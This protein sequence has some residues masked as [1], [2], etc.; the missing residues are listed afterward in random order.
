MARLIETDWP[1]FG[2]PALPPAS[3]AALYRGRIALLRARMEAAGLSVLLVYGDREHM[4]NL[5]WLTG[6]DPRFEEAVAVVRP[7]GP[8]RLLVGNEGW[9]YVPVSPL[10][11][12]DMAREVWP[13]FSLMNQPRAGARPLRHV[14]GEAMGEAGPGGV[15]CGVAGWKAFAAED[16]PE[17]GQMI[18]APAFVVDAARAAAARVVDAAALFM[19]PG[20]GLRATASA[21]E[22]AAHD[23]ANAIVT[24]AMRRVL[25]GLRPGM[26]DLEAAGLGRLGGM[27]LSCHPT[28]CTGAA[29]DLGLASPSGQVIARGAPLSLNFAVWRANCCRAGWIAAGPEDLPERARDY[30]EAFAGPYMDAMAAWF[31]ALRIGAPGGTLHALID[32]AL[33][34]DVFGITLNPGHLIDAEEW[35]SSPIYPGS[36]IP[37]ASGMVV[38]VDVIPASARYFSTRMEDTVA[39]ADTG[40]RA[41]IARDHP[42]LAAR[43]AQRRGFMADTL[44]IA[45]PEEVLPLSDLTGIVPPY[46]LAPHRVLAAG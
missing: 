30:V 27:P 26:T 18:A 8:V 5:H 1:D 34:R 19:D 33:P 32:R 46:F 42:R 17:P 37:L 14:L 36:T 35:L 23:Q 16:G 39:L 43:I 15:V 38:Q 4:G 22:I 20:T 28:F 6:F 40:L 10:F 21:A 12:D 13:G 9:A 11:P 29:A 44:G 24:G 45:L 2:M 3:D 41:A 31:G 25:F 7:T